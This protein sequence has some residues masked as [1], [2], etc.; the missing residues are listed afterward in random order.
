MKKILFTC[1]LAFAALAA[2]AQ[3]LK[4]TSLND[5]IGHG[6]D[7]IDVLGS[8]SLYQDAYKRKSYVEALEPWEYVFEKAPSLWCAFILTEPGCSSNSFSRKPMQ[9]RRRNTSTSS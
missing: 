9:T 5:R 3:D 8:L 1:A 6:Q 7:S 4:G 2:S